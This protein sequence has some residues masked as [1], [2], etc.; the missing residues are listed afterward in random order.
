MLRLLLIILISIILTILKLHLDHVIKMHTDIFRRI[1]KKSL[2]EPAAHIAVEHPDFVYP[3]D[4]ATA[5]DYR[6][7]D[8]YRLIQQNRQQI[9]DNAW[10][11][12]QAGSNTA[13]PAVETKCKRDIGLFIDYTSLDL[14]NGGNEYARKFALQYFDDQGNPLL[15][16][17]LAKN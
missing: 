7:K 1:A 12:M 5:S 4:P 2:I 14:V 6:F 9:I 16:V 17:C 11:T 3:G 10:T 15:M 13:D 8:A